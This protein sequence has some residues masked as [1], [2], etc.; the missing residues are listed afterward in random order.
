MRLQDIG[1]Y[2]LS[3][4]RAATSSEKTPLWRAE[5]LLTDRC[6]FA[7]PY[8]RGLRV[9]LR[10]DVPE[11]TLYPILDFLAFF[12]TKHYR[13]S[14]GEPTL[15]PHLTD[16]VSFA[17][18]NGASRIAVSTN[19]SASREAYDKLIEAGVDDFS[20]SLD[21]CCASTGEKM[22]G[23][24]G[25]WNKI[26]DNIRWI[27]S[28]VYTTVGVVYS[29]TN[30]NELGDIVSLAESLGVH[31]IR[32][33]PAAQYDS[34]LKVTPHVSKPFPI[35]KYR[36]DNMNSGKPV[37]GLHDTDSRFC[38]LVLDDV[39]IA[40]GMHFPCI[41]YLREQGDPIGKIGPQM[42]EERKAWFLSH[43]CY[44]DKICQGNC[45][46][47]CVDYNNQWLAKRTYKLPKMDS[48][49]FDWTSW[50]LGSTF[51]ELF[52]RPLRWDFVK[53]DEHFRASIKD[54]AIGWCSGDEV[55]CRP[56]PNTM[57][58]MFETPNGNAWIHLRK[59]EFFK[60]FGSI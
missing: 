49:L 6:N 46:D 31:D 26:V 15:Y 18:K 43:D 41:I 11:M 23:V 55:P 38:P 34:S 1:F 50:R 58:V 37:R 52:K 9:D 60:I 22:C 59:S 20:I 2:T 30:K 24:C 12:E 19:G 14:G 56:K 48:S 7:C 54:L 39:A 47:V 42:R 40:G 29:D 16:A 25:A 4:A 10:G 57:A 53:T 32:I 27:S 13:F 45:L 33:I 36:L 8:C 44:Q 5:V 3:D 35:L 21:A 51:E 28:K 17:K